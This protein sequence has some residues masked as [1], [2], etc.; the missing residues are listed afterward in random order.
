M[1]GARVNLPASAR[2]FAGVH[3]LKGHAPKADAAPYTTPQGPCPREGDRFR[4]GRAEGEEMR[5]RKGRKKIEGG[6]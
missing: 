5:D 3:D 4:C 6:A 2:G 1:P